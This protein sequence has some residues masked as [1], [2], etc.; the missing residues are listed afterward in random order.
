MGVGD[1]F[2]GPLVG[3]WLEIIGAAFPFP[4][5]VLLWGVEG[6]FDRIG[7]VGFDVSS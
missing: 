2:G 1:G 4:V 5:V 7:D 6:F 3:S